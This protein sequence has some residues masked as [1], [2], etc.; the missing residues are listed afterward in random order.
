VGG[1]QRRKATSVAPLSGLL[2]VIGGDPSSVCEEVQGAAPAG[3]PPAAS[4]RHYS[5]QGVDARIAG[6]CKDH[7]EAAQ[8]LAFNLVSHSPALLYLPLLRK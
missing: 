2:V 3:M 1:L 8:P 5:S 7:R 6:A 4:R